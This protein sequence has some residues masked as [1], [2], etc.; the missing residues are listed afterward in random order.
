MKKK[1]LLIV[2][3]FCIIAISQV[4]ALGIGVQ[5]NFNVNFE[6]GTKD[7]YEE[8]DTSVKIP[9]LGFSLLVSPTRQ[10]HFAGSYY[11]NETTNI[12]GLTGDYCPEGL[13]LKIA[14][15][16]PT[17]LFNPSAWWLSVNFGFGAFVNLMVINAEQDSSEDVNIGNMSTTVGLRVPVVLSFNFAGGLFEVFTSVTPSVGIRLAEKTPFA[18]FFFPIAI[19]ARIWL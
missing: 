16:Q 10:L 11:F 6:D 5:G 4:Q 3:V 13:S 8:D 17:L 9:N 1:I 14:G 2:A 19:G 18:N 12:F 15:S 7:T